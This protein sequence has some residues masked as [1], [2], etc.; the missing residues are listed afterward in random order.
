MK[1]TLLMV[2]MLAGIFAVKA[3]EEKAYTDEELETYATVMVW[4]ETEKANL[5]NLVRDSVEV[6]LE[7]EELTNT[8]YNEL[9]KADKAGKLEEVEATEEE[10]ATYQDIKSRIEGKTEKFKE[11]YV[12]KI[13][14][15]IGA[16]LYNRLRKDLK[17]DEDVVARY[18]A[19][20]VVVQ[21]KQAAEAEDTTKVESDTTS[22]SK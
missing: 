21:E 22:G 3:Q 20:Y 4:A 10:L 7:D 17:S 8:K 9:S 19:I 5:S 14:E 15:D 1:K 11:E 2:L 18:E 13:K 6:W 16:G 12:S